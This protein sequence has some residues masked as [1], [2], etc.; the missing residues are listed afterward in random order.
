MNSPQITLKEPSSLLQ[1][2]VQ[3]SW[4]SLAANERYI[5]HGKPISLYIFFSAFDL[6][7]FNVRCCSVKFSRPIVIKL[8]TKTLSLILPD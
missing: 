4:G 6:E 5:L 3:R 7:C 1:I 8:K 2:Y